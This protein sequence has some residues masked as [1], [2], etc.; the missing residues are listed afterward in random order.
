MPGSTGA[1]AAVS[2]LPGMTVYAWVVFTGGGSI[3]AKSSNVSSV[4]KN[5]P[6]DYTVN[7]AAM[8]DTSAIANIGALN[9]G[10]V[11]VQTVGRATI[12]SV[13]SASVVSYQVGTGY[14]DHVDCHVA[15]YR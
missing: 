2:P 10:G 15:I 9:A 3:K 6:G 12:S 11:S 14:T 7:F 13:S 4:V 5:G 1:M 8:P